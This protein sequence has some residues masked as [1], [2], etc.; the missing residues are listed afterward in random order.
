[1]SD[2]DPANRGVVISALRFTFTDTTGSFDTYLKPILTDLFVTMLK[3]SSLE[4]RKL[5]LTAVN[6]AAHTKAKIFVSTI[7]DVLPLVYQETVI[8]PE[9]IREVM[10][11]PFKHKV[12]DGLELRKSAYDTLYTM[13]ETS[14]AR[15][16]AT[17]LYDR[18]LAGSSDEHDIQIICNL[19]LAKLAVIGKEDMVKRLG[20][21][22]EKYKAALLVKLKDNAVK[23]ELEKSAELHRSILRTTLTIQN[24][25][26]AAAMHD[27]QWSQYYEWAKQSHGNEL[28]NLEKE[29][30]VKL[31]SR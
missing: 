3:D 27:Q 23:Q 4:N 18:I 29:E 30:S 11:G 8:K 21:I 28:Q 19:T 15:L 26:G 6:S 13:V 1:L 12:D 20:Q 22:A 5:A 2:R 7:R 10:M 31:S 9:L 24:N 17:E 14:Y 25:L 16:N